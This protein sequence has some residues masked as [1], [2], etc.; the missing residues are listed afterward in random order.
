MVKRELRHHKSIAKKVVSKETLKKIKNVKSRI[1]RIE[2]YKH[3]VKVSLER[4]MNSIE[5]QI[6]KHEKMHDTF[7]VF[8]KSRLLNL[9]IKY[10]YIT[11]N[12]KDLKVVLRLL[13][14]IETELKSLPNK[15]FGKY[16]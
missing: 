16:V 7:S 11:H 4:R 8:A 6:K 14:Q 5:D 10:F 3:S 15:R 9:K 13:H 1:E 12:K 2:L